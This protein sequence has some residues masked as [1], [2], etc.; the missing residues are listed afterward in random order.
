MA[1]AAGMRFLVGAGVVQVVE[2]G[3]EDVE[4]VARLEHEEEELLVVLAK[5]PEEHQ[6]LLK[7]ERIDGSGM[8]ATTRVP[9][10]HSGKLYRNM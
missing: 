2:D 6:Q 3:R 4:D 7:S 1:E 9:S 10:G 5:L 8:L